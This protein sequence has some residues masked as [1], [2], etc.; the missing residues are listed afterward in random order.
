[1]DKISKE[2]AQSF[3]VVIHMFET[4]RCNMD[5]L[6]IMYMYK[7][8]PMEFTMLDFSGTTADYVMKYSI[9]DMYG[10]TST[11]YQCYNSKTQ[12]GMGGTA[13]WEQEEQNYQI[14]KTF[15]KQ[16]I[17]KIVNLAVSA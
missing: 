10:K 17:S 14:K 1:M 15:S 6:N 4:S 9:E 5:S 12:R 13:N 16:E 2:I 3:A 11:E 8:T 7:I